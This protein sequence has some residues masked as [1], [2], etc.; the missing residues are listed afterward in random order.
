M[1]TSDY[2]KTFHSKGRPCTAIYVH[3]D[4]DRLV[5]HL[6]DLSSNAAEYT[7]I[8]FSMAGHQTTIVSVYVWTLTWDSQDRLRIA[9]RC[10]DHIICCD[11]FI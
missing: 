6:S 9:V 4:V 10:S 3:V 1:Y 8:T 2:R 5:L 11:D 7:T